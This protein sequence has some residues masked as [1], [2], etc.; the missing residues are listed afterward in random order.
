M[1]SIMSLMARRANLRTELATFYTVCMFLY[2]KA[3]KSVTF[4]GKNT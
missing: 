1:E 2:V 4:K 3:K